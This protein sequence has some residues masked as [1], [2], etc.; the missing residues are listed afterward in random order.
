MGARAFDQFTLEASADDLKARASGFLAYEEAL[1]REAVRLCMARVAHEAA[2]TPPPPPVVVHVPTP[3]SPSP[4][5]PGTKPLKV[6]VS[7]FRGDEGENLMFWT[8]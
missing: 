4:G 8:R 6:S 2:A 7:A 3:P 1:M 5:V